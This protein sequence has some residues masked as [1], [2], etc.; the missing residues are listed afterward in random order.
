MK[1]ILILLTVLASSCITQEK[2][3]ERYP[4]TPLRETIEYH[5]TLVVTQEK[6]M[7]D[8]LLLRQVD[9]MISNRIVKVYRIPSYVKD[10]SGVSMKYLNDSTVILT[11]KCKGD[12]IKMKGK[13][14]IRT[15]TQVQEK[16]VMKIPFY[17]WILLSLLII[18]TALLTL[19][20]IFR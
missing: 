2:C 3:L 17:Y 5:D 4:S 18:T 16:T 8:T 7:V 20:T 12:T 9:T 13:D 11:A 14:V 19:K 15:I 10:G 6:V 1:Y